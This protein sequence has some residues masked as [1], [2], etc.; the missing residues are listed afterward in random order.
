[1]VAVAAHALDEHLGELAV[2]I[3]APSLPALFAEAGRALAETMRATP[4]PAPADCSEEIV[5]DAR[6]R[7]ALLVAWL[8]EIVL[9]AE[10]SK[11]LF[12]RFEIAHLSDG[13]LVAVVHGARVAALRNPVKAAT[14]H[15]LSIEEH[16]GTFTARVILDV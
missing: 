5:L 3:E 2:R 14:Y 1:M 15:R 6:D 7:E 11:A 16:D 8:N 4:L 13:H 12:T 10:V 9:R